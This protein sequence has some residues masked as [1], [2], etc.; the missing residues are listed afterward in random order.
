MSWVI[1]VF[2]SSTA[3]DL[4]EHR[5]AVHDR[6]GRTG[7]FRCIRQEDFGAQDAG[8]VNFCRRKSQ[9]AG[10]FVGLIGMRRGWEP[11]GDNEKRSIT[12]MEHDWARDAGR[13]RSLWVMPENFPLPT[14]ERESSAAHRR[15][16]AFCK[17]IMGGGGRIVSQKGFDA[18][19]LLAAGKV[20]N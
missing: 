13:P 4:A 16:M 14:N 5:K 9:E 7:L 3:Q 15:Q 17:R 11:E 19:D 2:L 10:M 18:P 6:L 20:A 1:D 12:E 8:A